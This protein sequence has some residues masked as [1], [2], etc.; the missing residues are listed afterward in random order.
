MHAGG[1]IPARERARYVSLANRTTKEAPGDAG[2]FSLLIS[3]DQYLAC[4]G[5]PPQ[6]KRS[7]KEVLMV[8]TRG[9]KARLAA[10]GTL[11]TSDNASSGTEMT[12]TARV[13]ELPEAELIRQAVTEAAIVQAVGRARGV[14]R[15]A[16]N[17]VEIWMIL[18][19]TIVPLALD[20]V[21]QFTDIEPNKIDVMIDRGLVPS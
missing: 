16:A 10:A 6:L 8:C 18:S 19:D 2:A 21:A 11:P 15:S 7:T 14:N 5:A 12:L 3:R 9:L 13:F 1:H 20:S 4:T 17:P